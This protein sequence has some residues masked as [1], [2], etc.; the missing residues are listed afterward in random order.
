MAAETRCSAGRPTGKINSQREINKNSHQSPPVFEIFHRLLACQIWHGSAVPIQPGPSLTSPASFRS[1]LVPAAVSA[2]RLQIGLLSALVLLSTIT[3]AQEPQPAADQLLLHLPLQTDFRD[4]VSGRVLAGTDDR[5]QPSGGA[6]FLRGAP[7]TIPAEL[8]KSLGTGDFTVSTWLRFA[9]DGSG[10]TGDLLCQYDPARR[11]GLHLT[12][13]TATGITSCQSNLRHLQFGIDDDR[14]GV[15]QKVGRPGD[16]I[17][18]FALAVHENELYAGTCEPAAGKSGRVYRYDGDSRWIDCGAPDQSNSVT[19][20]A[21]WRG[22]LYAGTGKY[23]LA[24]SSLAESPNAELGGRIFRYEGGT[25]WKL[26]GQLPGTEAVGGLVVF[27]D[28]LYASSLYKP[29]GFFRL[30]PDSTEWTALPI[31]RSPDDS[32]QPTDRRVESLHVT[33]DAIV[34]SSY[35]GGHVY[36]FDGTA[37]QDLGRLGENTQTYSFVSL[38]GQL[39]VGT[40]PSGRVYSHAAD[41]SWQ[42]AGRLGEELE[43]MGMLVHNGRLFAGSLPLG[44][45]YTLD[46]PGRWVLSARLDQT[47]DVKYRRVWTMAEHRGALFCSTLPS[48]E[49]WTYRQGRQ[50]QWGDTLPEGWQHVAAVRTGEQLTLFL[51]GRELA[52]SAAPTAG[53][54][55]YDLSTQAPLQIGGGTNGALGGFLKEL[56]IHSRALTP[57]EIRQLATAQ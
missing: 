29:A 16:S 53:E 9:P 51:N 55:P 2:L 41:G 35:D 26:C 6:A 22:R 7:L 32:G 31:P 14:G 33:A 17:L 56:R 27:R 38:N 34:A 10:H 15:W 25:R 3:S 36:R 5:P 47:P 11:R 40:W 8:L 48:G 54:R 18:A 28:R 46:A 49:V 44:Q 57:A 21:V 52:S 50:V 13:K 37:W 1:T 39:L 19:S 12:L 30:E 24:G 20:M 45:V 23:R 42:D 4:T 43:V